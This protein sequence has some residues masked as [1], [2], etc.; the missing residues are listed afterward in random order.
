MKRVLLTG[1]SG[2]V[3]QHCAVQLLEKGYTVRGSLR[4]LSKE[5]EV[6]KGLAKVV[7]AKK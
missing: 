6:R 2:F 3:G 4:N 5:E 7:D 1:I